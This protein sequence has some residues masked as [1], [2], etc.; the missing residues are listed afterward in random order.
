LGHGS[1]Q[2]S[3]LLYTQDLVSSLLLANHT[4]Y[5]TIQ[6]EHGNTQILT[7]TIKLQN[8]PSMPAI[9]TP[10]SSNA[11][12]GPLIVRLRR[13]AAPT[14]SL[15]DVVA[16]FDATNSA[17]TI[18]IEM[19][20]SENLDFGIPSTGLYFL[21]VVNTLG[22]ILNVTLLVEVQ[23][24]SVLD[25]GP[26]CNSTVIDLTL[27]SNATSQTGTGDYQ[28]FTVKNNTLLVGV[29]TTKLKGNAPA[30]IASVFSFSSNES[31]L[32]GSSGDTISF[33]S[34]TYVPPVIQIPDDS[35]QEA[36]WY[37]SV[38]APEGTEYYIWANEPCPNNCY[39]SKPPGP[40][41]TVV[42]TCNAYNGT[43]ECSKG[44]SGLFCDK[45]GPNVVLIVVIV[46]VVAV[47]IALV[48]AVVV[49]WFLR[50]R[51]KNYEQI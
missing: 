32:L 45:S 46:V 26:Q 5:F 10:N 11:T 24:C 44:H 28:L 15:F 34:S 8:P 9:L 50:N 3:P 16:D 31:A 13:G 21:Q 35:L 40:N 27:S 48:I 43:C 14:N 25:F 17:Y 2:N 49:W 33:I 20:T 7:T 42:G 30:L 18:A 37:V 12:A 41:S 19:P 36:T 6:L 39:G 1:C 51:R 22:D 4:T 23:I 47:V 29:G 38:W